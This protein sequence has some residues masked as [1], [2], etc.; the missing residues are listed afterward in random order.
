MTTFV[1]ARA[2]V[3]AALIAAGVRASDTPGADTPYVYVAGDGSGDG[4]RVVTGQLVAS[5]RLVM[6]GGAWDES[7]AAR[8]LDTLKQTVLET[9]RSLAG[10]RLTSGVSR[11]GARDWAGA[12]YLSADVTAER[13]IDI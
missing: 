6:V 11:D 2:E 8:D 12:L 5:F 7:A 10:W 9:L 13:L 4:S 1:D 3:I